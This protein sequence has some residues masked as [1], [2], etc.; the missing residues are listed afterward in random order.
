MPVTP[1]V[2]W[3][4]LSEFRR[5]LR[6]LSDDGVWVKELREAGKDAAGMIVP[7][8][9]SFAPRRTGTL[10]GSIRPLASGSSFAVAAGGAA[11]PYARP[12]HWGWPRRNIAANPF[13]T[14]AADAQQNQVLAVFK[15][16]VTRITAEAFPI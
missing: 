16:H 9:R 10:A 13:I 14:R 12:I 2:T 15:D 5:D 7:T 3:V 4:G 8:A 1:T 11:V 6:R